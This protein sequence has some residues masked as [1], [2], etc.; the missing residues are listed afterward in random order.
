MEITVNEATHF[1]AF[2][3]LSLLERIE[4]DQYNVEDIYLREPLKL[5]F[6]ESWILFWGKCRVNK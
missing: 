3:S 6:E 2:H 4:N 5:A 1:A